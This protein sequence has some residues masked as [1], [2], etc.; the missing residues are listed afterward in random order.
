MNF[1][2]I[3]VVLVHNTFA[4]THLGAIVGCYQ[5]IFV[6]YIYANWFDWADKIN[7]PFIKVLLVI[8]LPIL[9]CCFVLNS[10][11][12]DSCHKLGNI[13]E[14]PYA[15]WATNIWHP[16]SCKVISNEK[17][18]P[19]TPSCISCST[20]GISESSKQ[21]FRTLSWPW[22]YNFPYTKKKLFSRLAFSFA[23][24]YM[25]QKISSNEVFK[26][27]LWPYWL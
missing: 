8:K 9:L 17:W 21:C 20:M 6:P 11:F 10:M 4:S 5:N 3:T 16:R 23:L 24:D 13:G 7:P 2:V 19:S 15:L 1:D 14:H 12:V 25:S 26:N 22:Q 18:P 27:F